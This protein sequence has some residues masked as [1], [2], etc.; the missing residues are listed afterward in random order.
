MKLIKTLVLFSNCLIIE[1]D[2]SLVKSVKLKFRYS[3]IILLIVFL[4]SKL[5]IKLILFIK[6]INMFVMMYI[7]TGS[8]LFIFYI[9]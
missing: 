6:N 5:L 9:L 8:E 7:Q 2:V 1:S 3:L 4:K